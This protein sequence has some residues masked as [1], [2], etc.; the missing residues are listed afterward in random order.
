[1]KLSRLNVIAAM[2]LWSA[3]PPSNASAEAL[4]D[5]IVGVWSFVSSLDIYADGRAVDRWG[6]NPR[7]I[8][9]S[10]VLTENSL[11][12]NERIASPPSSGLCQIL[13]P[14]ERPAG[15]L[16]DSHMRTTRPIGISDFKNRQF[17][18]V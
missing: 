13:P 9:I 12:L 4:K 16:G 17:A 18:R 15:V 2:I 14:A 6:S 11:L 5:Q 3:W 8:F 1:M 7:G 10:E